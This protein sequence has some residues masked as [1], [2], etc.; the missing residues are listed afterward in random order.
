M[1]KV[2]FI[3][4]TAYSGSTM[5][6]MMLGNSPETFSAGEV[7]GLF[8]PR[9]LQHIYP[10]CGCGDKNCS[11]WP[12]VRKSGELQLYHELSKRFPAANTLID[13][14]K[15]PFWIKNQRD[16]LESRGI[17][18]SIVLIWK[19][20]AEFALSRQK[21]NSLK[22]W[23]RAWIN[24]HRLFFSQIDDWRSIKYRDIVEEPE[25]KLKEVCEVIGLP[26]REGM[27]KYWGKT[28]HTIFGNTSA[29]FHTYD[30][31]SQDFDKSV[32][33]LNSLKDGTAQ[34]E[35]TVKSRHRSIYSSGDIEKRL[36]ESVLREAAGG[37]FDAIIDHLKSHD[38]EKPSLN[39]RVRD[40]SVR[41]LSFPK[42]YVE[43]FRTK[44]LL[45]LK[46]FSLRHMKRIN[47][48]S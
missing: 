1:K 38:V 22:S 35:T 21:R 47:A 28:H 32:D 14:S 12:D 44:R 45:E 9:R 41:K 30:V 42:A 23:K 27:E 37:D 31:N 17:S 4:G 15:D 43:L 34:K 7:R 18:T 40:S 5:L 36:P 16:R 33:S 26:Y 19:T 46:W 8:Q 2:V 10:T 13:S 24:Y 11:L 6:D 3:G 20:P 25:R 48:V 29:K 39:D